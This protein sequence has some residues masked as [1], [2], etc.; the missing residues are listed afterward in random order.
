MSRKYWKKNEIEEFRQ[1]YPN[2]LNRELVIKF[3]CELY[4]LY[5]LAHRIGCYKSPEYLKEHVNKFTFTEPSIAHRFQKGHKTWNSGIKGI[6]MSIKTEFKKGSIPHNTKYDGYE[7]KRDQYWYIRI[8]GKFVLKHRYIWESVNGKIPEGMVLKFKDG[9]TDNIQIDNL[10]LCS[11]KDHAIENSIHN[12]PKEIIE[13][14]R[15]TKKI[16]RYATK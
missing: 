15:L 2:T 8:N 6:R 3:N 12:Y 13:V 4:Q 16:E 9:N 7:S 1:L 11:K 5:N 10:R 14:I